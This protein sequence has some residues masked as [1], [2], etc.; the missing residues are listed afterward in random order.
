MKILVID[1]L[2]PM[3]HVGYVTYQLECLKSL[4]H[5]ITFYSHKEFYEACN[6]KE[7]EF[8][9]FP[10]YLY[11]KT[12]SRFKPLLERIQGIVKLLYINMYLIFYKYDAIL[13]MSYDIMSF[14]IFKSQRNTFIIN[15]N[16]VTDFSKRL[17]IFLHRHISDKVTYVALAPFIADY[18]KKNIKNRIVMIPHGITKKYD[19]VESSCR[20]LY[21]GKFI[22]VPTTSSC[23]ENLLMKIINSKSVNNYLKESGIKLVIKS[24]KIDISNSNCVI[25]SQYID[26]ETYARIMGEAL[27][28]L[29]LYTDKSFYNRVSAVLMECIGSNIPIIS[30]RNKSYE[31][32]L[33]LCI[34]NYIIDSPESFLQCLVSI[35][36]SDK[37][38]YKSL[39]MLDST[40][41]WKKYLISQ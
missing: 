38:Y 21:G 35:D 5:K 39:N 1:Y 20:Q 7:I 14:W 32:Y 4:G 18:L 41:Y 12:G 31:N 29:T 25:I 11:S 34:Y 37:I 17:K 40:N 10:N 15:H 19:R 26:A 8:K 27:A 13:F 23:D 30:A 6:V 36:N 9:A 22:Y 3:G 33:D 24:L 2:A 16:N 28:V